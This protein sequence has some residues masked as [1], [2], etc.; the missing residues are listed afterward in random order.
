MLRIFKV[1]RGA[2]KLSL[3]VRR[4]DVTLTGIKSAVHLYQEYF[5][6]NSFGDTPRGIFLGTSHVAQGF[7]RTP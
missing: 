1:E 7:G 3:D 6:I 4:H 5:P 2:W